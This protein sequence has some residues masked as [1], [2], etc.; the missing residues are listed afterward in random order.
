MTTETDQ[1]YLKETYA[2]EREH[3]IVTTSMLADR[4]GTSAA[5]V[6]GMLKKL[7]ARGWV[8][9]RRYKGITLTPAGRAIAL[10]VVRHHRLLETYLSRALGV[11]WD[12]VHE[13][14]ER[15]EHV[16]SDYLEDRIDEML[17]HPEFDPHGAPIPGRDGTLPEP[18]RTPL[19]AMDAGTTVEIV[20]VSDR[21]REILRYLD[22]LKLSLHTRLTVVKREPVD[23]LLSIRVKGKEITLGERAA[24]QIFV[25]AWGEHGN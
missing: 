11:P 13:E 14:A 23:G 4:F 12:R 21:D 6:T 20:E 22:R 16:L 24:R 17:G 3:D 25:R 9:Y 2:L 5:T 18:E 8:V 19:S 1:N 15:L 7:A 10:D